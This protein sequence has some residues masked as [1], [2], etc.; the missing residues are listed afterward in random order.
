MG[1]NLPSFVAQRDGSITFPS[2]LIAN[3][4]GWGNAR[5]PDMAQI[6]GRTHYDIAQ[7]YPLG[8]KLEKGDRIWR[9][10]KYGDQDAG[11]VWGT[12]TGQALDNCCLMGSTA[13]GDG[14]VMKTNTA[15][16]NP[17]KITEASVTAD[18]YA[19]GYLVV[20]SGST[21]WMGHIV[22][23]TASATTPAN[24]VEL[25][26][27]TGCPVALTS[28]YTT[29]ITKSRYKDVVRH[30]GAAANMGYEIVGVHN[31]GYSTADSEG[32]F[33]WVQTRG[34]TFMVITI[35]H[36]GDAHGERILVAYNGA[37]R[38]EASTTYQVIGHYMQEYDAATFAY[39]MVFLTLEQGK[40]M[41]KKIEKVFKQEGYR[42]V[43][44]DEVKKPSPKKEEKPK[45]SQQWTQ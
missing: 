2:I 35:A 37:A 20:Q 41:G 26:M 14:T 19:G 30:S 33:G 22:S 18:Q 15:L 8:T 39:P 3:Q 7:E 38:C 25:D 6:Y 42:L 31:G 34:P 27:E 10:V 17:I 13:T 29:E 9:Y 1:K 24:E 12:G 44:T 28:G 43:E 40:E 21:T 4:K 5:I 45:E 36:Q 23:N 11:A 32:Y 16:A